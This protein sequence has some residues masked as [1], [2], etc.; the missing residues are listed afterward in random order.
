[1]EI[2]RAVTE[3]RLV[4]WLKSVCL[5]SGRKSNLSRCSGCAYEFRVILVLLQSCSKTLHEEREPA[6]SQI[7]SAR[8]SQDL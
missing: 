6:N 5:L 7:L 1:M 4:T 3:F 8:R 2:E